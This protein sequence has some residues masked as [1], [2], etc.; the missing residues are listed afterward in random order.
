MFPACLLLV[1][2]IFPV[3]ASAANINPVETNTQQQ[4]RQQERLKELRQRQEEAPDARGLGEQLQKQAPIVTDIIPDNEQPCFEITKVELVG[5]AADQ[6]QFALNKVLNSQAAQTKPI[7]G[8]CLG[9]LGI[10]A[11]M[12]QVQ[13]A[14]IA[15]GYVTTRVL[16]SPQ[17][18]KSGVLQLTI[19]PGRVNAV[20]FTPDSS[21]RS[22]A[23]NVVP[24]NNGDILNLRDIE[25]ALENF[26]RVPTAEADIQIVPASNASEGVNTNQP[27]LSDL[28][29][30]YQQRFPVRVS[31]SLDDA[32]ANVTGKH[33]GGVTLAIVE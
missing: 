7:L 11:V 12:T 17:D 8:R 24:I 25:Q 26:K 31:L 22:S 4:I 32:G 15:K 6:F 30:R 10:N 28:V 20:R 5:D 3:L 19:V 2:A 29:I 21:R 13:N 1:C 27:G 16:A 33:Q 9:V 14:I 23:L 18:L